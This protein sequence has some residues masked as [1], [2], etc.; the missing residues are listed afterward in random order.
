MDLDKLT[1]E[2]KE[3]AKACESLN[4]LLELARAEGV[5]LSEE[6]LDAISGG[7]DWTD[8]CTVLCGIHSKN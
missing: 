6:Q 2:Q 5:E 7:T 4:E 3:K 8:L 1:P